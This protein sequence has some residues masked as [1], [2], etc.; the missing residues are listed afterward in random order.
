MSMY[1]IYMWLG[2][3]VGVKGLGAIEFLQKKNVIIYYTITVS[4]VRGCVCVY[5]YIYI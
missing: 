5:I 2:E 1:L 3:P 4:H